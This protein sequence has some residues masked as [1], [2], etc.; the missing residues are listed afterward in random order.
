MKKFAFSFLFLSFA[1]FTS[2]YAQKDIVI[3]NQT[4]VAIYSV[5][6]SSVNHPEWGDDLLGQ[7][8]LEPGQKITITFP[9]GYDCSVDIKV[10]ADPDDADS[11]TFEDANI[12]NINGITL[13][14][15]GKYSVYDPKK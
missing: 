14:G 12:C 3:T 7:D 5:F 2:S 10:S 9:E 4:G 6:A 11:L 8:V 15:N 1:F 13:K